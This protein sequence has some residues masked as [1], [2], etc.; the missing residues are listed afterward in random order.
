MPRAVRIRFT[1]AWDSWTAERPAPRPHHLRQLA[2]AD[3]QLRKLVLGPTP[4]QLIAAT[5]SRQRL[6]PSGP[7]SKTARHPDHI[8]G[9]RRVDW[10]V[11]PRAT[12]PGPSRRR[13]SPGRPSRH[14]WRREYLPR[15]LKGL[16][17]APHATNA[18]TASE[19][20]TAPLRA[21]PAP[22]LA[23]P[24][25]SAPRQHVGSEWAQNKPPT[26]IPEDTSRHVDTVAAV[27]NA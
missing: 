6:A 8:Q 9:R 26:V 12:P 18:S 22:L 21:A 25:P 17:T 3:P 1:R 16:Q 11:G 24:R 7:S 4:R 15:T 14:L 5:R 13:R 27:R 2:H 20:S 23:A 19:A 10:R